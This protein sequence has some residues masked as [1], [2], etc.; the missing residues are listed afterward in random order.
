MFGAEL[1]KRAD[2]NKDGKVSLD[3]VP[4]ERR[5]RFKKLLERA[6]KDGDHAL[7]VEEG[8]QFGAEVRRRAQAGRKAVEA[9][10]KPGERKRP[11][12][13][14]PKREKPE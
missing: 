4:Q 1:F 11:E 13:K 6:D 8:R 12:R 10:R 5:E 2:A 9:R 3:E 14:G 7:S